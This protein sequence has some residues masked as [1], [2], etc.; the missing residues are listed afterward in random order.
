MA[1]REVHSDE[2]KDAFELYL[3]HNGERHDLIEKE[4][5]RR[6]WSSFRKAILKSR[7]FGENRR[8]GW[9]DQFGWK[10]S[11]ELKIATANTAAAT[12]AESLLFEVEEIRKKLF[13]EIQVKGI[14][15]LGKDAVYQH[16]KY[17]TKSIEI[18]DRLNDARDNYANFVFF[19]KRLMA[20]SPKISPEL[21]RTLVDA[22]EPLI[23]W[24]ESEFVTS[25]K[26]D[27]A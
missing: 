9:I 4:M 24:A 6:G 21:A 15:K 10:K 20:A 11:L 25:E 18:L 2:L 17:V 26:S 5:H 16:D 12:S 22:E 7:G 13:I 3:L 19:L 8:D 27:E 1:K 23:D 14:G